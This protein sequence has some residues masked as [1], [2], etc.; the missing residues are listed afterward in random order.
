[1][2]TLDYFV[3]VVFI[4][5]ILIPISGLTWTVLVQSIIKMIHDF[6]KEKNIHY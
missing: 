6:R 4:I 3:K 2:D 5:G 1:M